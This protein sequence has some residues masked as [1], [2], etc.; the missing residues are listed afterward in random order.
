MVTIL[1]VELKEFDSLQVNHRRDS[2]FIEVQIYILA[3]RLS[4]FSIPN[5]RAPF[6]YEH[7]F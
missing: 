4:Q 1:T 3:N 6:W 2:F 7:F 5:K